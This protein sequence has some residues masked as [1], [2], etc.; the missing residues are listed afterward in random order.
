MQT[1]H[2]SRRSTTIHS[3]NTDSTAAAADCRI[4]G[5]FLLPPSSRSQSTAT[6][7]LPYVVGAWLEHRRIVAALGAQQQQQQQQQE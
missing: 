1:Y 3:A 6:A 7:A 2:P 4:T 5:P